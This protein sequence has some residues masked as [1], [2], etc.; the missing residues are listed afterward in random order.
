MPY[1]T[2]HEDKDKATVTLK[3]INIYPSSAVIHIFP[4]NATCSLYQRTYEKKKKPTF[5]CI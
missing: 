1:L 5:Y 3:N 2:F 4:G